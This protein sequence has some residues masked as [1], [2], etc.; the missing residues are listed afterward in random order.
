MRNL[1]EVTE[2]RARVAAARTGSRLAG[3]LVATPP[4][5]WPLPPPSI[6]GQLRTLAA[7]GLRVARRWRRAFEQLERGRPDGAHWYVAALGVETSLQ[8]RGIGGA[9]LASFVAQTR[10][11]GV[12]VWLETDL[13]RNLA[14]YGRHGFEV[15]EEL[16]VLATPVWRLR[17]A[18]PEAVF[19]KP[20]LR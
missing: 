11:D 18:A 13:E 8:G 10:S 4:F 17:R 14:F 3:V 2:G 19:A 9:L 7:Q 20:R 12:E 16:M 5:G 6:L 1:F 15:R